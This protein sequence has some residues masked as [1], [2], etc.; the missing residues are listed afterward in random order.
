MLGSIFGTD[1][2]VI[3]FLNKLAD[4]I[5]H[6]NQKLTLI[7]NNSSSIKELLIQ[8]NELMKGVEEIIKNQ[9]KFRISYDLART[10]IHEQQR[11]NR[12]QIDMNPSMYLD[13]ILEQKLYD[14]R[15]NIEDLTRAVE[16]IKDLKLQE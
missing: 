7:S 2:E 16:V 9:G 8:N 14:I 10:T 15:S 12:Q 5:N 13:E 11:K 6:M 1:P 4:A 3:K